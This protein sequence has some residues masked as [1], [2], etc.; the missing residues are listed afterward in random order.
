MICMTTCHSQTVVGCWIGFHT[1]RIME[2]YCMVLWFAFV[3]KSRKAMWS[4]LGYARSRSQQSFVILAKC[5]RKKKVQRGRSCYKPEKSE[6]SSWHQWQEQQPL[7]QIP[8]HACLWLA[9]NW[10][11]CLYQWAAHSSGW[12]LF[13][14]LFTYTYFYPRFWHDGVN[15]FK[16]T[17]NCRV[18]RCHHLAWGMCWELRKRREL[19]D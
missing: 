19:R 13:N 10:L 2:L 17:G 4:K 3:S 16:H 8:L 18:F 12:L 15:R 1:W 6:M 11:L 14:P 5:K 7:G 9:E